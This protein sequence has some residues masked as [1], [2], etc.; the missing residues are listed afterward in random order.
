[1]FTR[2]RAEE[3]WLANSMELTGGWASELVW[4]NDEL[5]IAWASCDDPESEM[6]LPQTGSKTNDTRW[7]LKKEYSLSQWR[8]ISSEIMFSVS[9]GKITD[10]G[11]KSKS[12]LARAVP[13]GLL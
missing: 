9:L 4:I 7:T 5:W 13:V 8:D 6:V 1:M 2:E 12:A 10:G 11:I 3:R